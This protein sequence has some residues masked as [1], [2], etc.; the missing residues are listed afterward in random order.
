MEPPALTG[1]LLHAACH[2]VVTAGE[3]IAEVDFEAVPWLAVAEMREVDR[4]MT[5]ELGVSIPCLPWLA[6]TMVSRMTH[7][8]RRPTGR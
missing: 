1:S 3:R 4:L 2:V 6:A 7:G 8:C 5:E